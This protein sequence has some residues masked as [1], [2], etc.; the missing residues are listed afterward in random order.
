M[1]ESSG[2]CGNV[3]KHLFQ[4]IISSYWVLLHCIVLARDVKINTSAIFADISKDTILMILTY[5]NIFLSFSLW[6][7]SQAVAEGCELA[8]V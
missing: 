6:T 5:L 8:V 2:E 3:P 1:Q 7:D 4:G